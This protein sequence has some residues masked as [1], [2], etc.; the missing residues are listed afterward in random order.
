MKN[1]IVTIT[2]L[3]IVQFALLNCDAP[4]NNPLDP[5]N[6]D[7]PYA[8]L[9][10]KVQSISLIP[11]EGAGVYWRNYDVSVKTDSK[12]NFQFE[13]LP[14]ENGWIFFEKEGF[15]RDSVLVN[16]GR[17]KTVS[18]QHFMDALPRLENLEVYSIVINIWPDN[19]EFYLT[20]QAA[21]DDPDSDI[22]TVFWKVPDLG[23][24]G[25]LEQAGAK[26]YEL[27]FRPELPIE[28]IVGHDFVITVQDQ[29]G[30]RTDVGNKQVK[31]VIKDDLS[32]LSPSGGVLVS[33]RPTLKWQEFKPG[34]THTYRL[35]VSI[36][37]QFS[38]PEL[39]W[40]AENL[41][42][43][44]TSYTVDQDLEE[45]EEPDIYFWVIWA[46]DEFQ[47][48]ARSRQLTFNVSE[49]AKRIP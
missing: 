44:L 43:T 11:L 34:F 26:T 36:D 22:D 10:G 33:P 16:W 29:S 17:Q 35:E 45:L 37:V 14:P 25:F 23:I 49:T 18:I 30:R 3:W 6:P 48:R 38:Q 1:I 39:V 2:F 21:V 27:T 46:I 5:E 24:E 12:G 32:G 9:Q 4:R 31:R 20:I 47:N 7:S 15:H 41:P 42:A 40:A 8:F 19:K 13:Y 28:E